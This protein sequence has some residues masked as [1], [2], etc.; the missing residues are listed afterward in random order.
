MPRYAHELN[1]VATIT[2]S[3]EQGIV[4]AR[5]ESVVGE[6][7]YLLRYIR[8]DGVANESWWTQSALTDTTA[9]VSTKEG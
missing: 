7:Q 8:R 5:A 6:P 4:I 1:D 9:P 3:G 2:C